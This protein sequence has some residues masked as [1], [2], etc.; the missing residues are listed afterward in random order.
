MFTIKTN[1]NIIIIYLACRQYSNK[2][3]AVP[4]YKIMPR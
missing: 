2:A 3:P 4:F 1:T